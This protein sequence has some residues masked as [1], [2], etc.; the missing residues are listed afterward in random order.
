M[1][2]AA[3]ARKPARS[4][5]RRPARPRAATGPARPRPRSGRTAAARTSRRPSASRGKVTTSLTGA[6]LVPVAVGR[7]AVA[8]GGLADTAL[9]VRLTRG[10]LWIGLMGMLLVGIVGL[11]VMALQFNATAS[12]TASIS[13]QLK[14]EN[15][16]LRADIASGLS[17]QRLQQVASRL[18]LIVPEPGAILYLKHRE[19]DAAAA[20]GRLRDGTITAGAASLPAAAPPAVAV[21]PATAGIATETEPAPPSTAPAEPAVPTP[22]ASPDPAAAAAPQAPTPSAAAPA[23]GAIAP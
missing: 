10:R 2:A 14:R 6:W 12:K 18:G 21:D 5:P 11:N 16:A 1:S 20:A 22:E 7:T 19:G 4:A 9:F 13:D 17:D 15:S 23:G 8:V 3:T